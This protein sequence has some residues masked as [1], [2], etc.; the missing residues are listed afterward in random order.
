MKNETTFTCDDK[1]CNNE[2]TVPTHQYK[3]YNTHFCSKKCAGANRRMSKAK[4]KK[5]EKKTVKQIVSENVRQYFK[6]MR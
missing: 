2:R 5:V 3:R 6:E 4:C 1:D